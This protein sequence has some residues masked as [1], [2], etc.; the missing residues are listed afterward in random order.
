MKTVR[1]PFPARA[2]VRGFH[3]AAILLL[4]FLSS[5]AAAESPVAFEKK[6]LT[7]KFH[8]EAAAIGDIDRD[9]HADVVYGPHWYAG[10]AFTERFEIYPAKDFDPNNYSD[11]FMTAVADVD[12]DGRLDVLVNEWPGKPVHWFKNPAR[13]V[14]RDP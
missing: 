7:D 2:A 5:S 1:L 10:P 6:V 13:G 3:P 12:A 11:N 14:R 4:P 8:A 9:G